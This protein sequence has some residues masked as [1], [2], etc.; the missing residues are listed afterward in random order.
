[1]A[2]LGATEVLNVQ[3]A[4]LEG[5]VWTLGEVVIFLCSFLILNNIYS[6]EGSLRASLKAMRTIMGPNNAKC[7]VW[8]HGEYLFFSLHLFNTNMICL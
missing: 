2:G 3:R 6:T 4:F 1:M 5:V 7:V 8:A